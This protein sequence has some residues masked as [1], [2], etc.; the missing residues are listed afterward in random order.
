ML[1]HR[2]AVDLAPDSADKRAV[3]ECANARFILLNGDITEQHML[4]LAQ[5]QKDVA[6]MP[7]R[8]HD[9]TER[10][11]VLAFCLRLAGQG[12]RLRKERDQVREEAYRFARIAHYRQTGTRVGDLFDPIVEEAQAAIDAS[13]AEAKPVSKAPAPAPVPAPEPE[14][15]PRASNKQIKAVVRALKEARID[16]ETCERF[17]KQ[18]HDEAWPSNRLEAEMRRLTAA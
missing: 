17:R 5:L 15:A 8:V 13:I 11:R 4:M 7:A 9:E 1:S 18:A 12:S 2:E 3:I 14:P 6:M 10:L 16:A